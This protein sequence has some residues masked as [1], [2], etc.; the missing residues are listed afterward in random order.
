M[1]PG[2]LPP[3]P[4]PYGPSF[5]SAIPPPPP[6][7]GGVAVGV[8][9]P[10]MSTFGGIGGVNASIRTSAVEVGERVLSPIPGGVQTFGGR[11]GAPVISG[12]GVI[13]G[14]IAAGPILTSSVMPVGGVVRQS[15]IV[16]TSPPVVTQSFVPPPPPIMPPIAPVV[17]GIRASR[18][19]VGPTSVV[20]VP[21]P[22]QYFS[23]GI[24]GSRTILP[25]APPVM[26]SVINQPPVVTTTVTDTFNSG[27]RSNFIGTPSTMIST[28]I[29]Q[30]GTVTTTVKEEIIE[31]INPQQTVIAPQVPLVPQVPTMMPHQMMTPPIYPGGYGCCY[32]LNNMCPRICGLPWWIPLLLGLLAAGGLLTGLGYGYKAWK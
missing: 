8:P 9:Y 5:P 28:P 11:I 30:P 23:S 27:L 22:P 20:P 21:P 18:T 31:T 13:S 16:S 4:G 12:G 3:G 32:Q 14:P 26:T 2:M 25:V 29:I 6:G 7:L 19:L 1:I 15:R 24:R 10:G 17:S